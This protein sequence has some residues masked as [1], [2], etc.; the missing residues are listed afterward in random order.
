VFKEFL[1][2]PSTDVSVKGYA[3]VEQLLQKPSKEETEI[4][5]NMLKNGKVLGGDKI[6]SEYL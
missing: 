6:I 1:N 2:Q 3:T 4:V 5:L